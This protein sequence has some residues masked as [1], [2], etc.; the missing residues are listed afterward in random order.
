MILKL[1]KTI[2]KWCLERSI[3]EL[4]NRGA[5]LGDIK[6]NIEE[7]DGEVYGR[8]TMVNVVNYYGNVFAPVWLIDQPRKV[9]IC[10]KGWR[11]FLREEIGIIPERFNG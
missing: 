2:V 6:I 1:K 8:L 9:M 5:V 11:F 10:T 4:E 7:V 3:K